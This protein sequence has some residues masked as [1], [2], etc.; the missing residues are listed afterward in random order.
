MKILSIIGARPQFI[1]CAPL[2]G[3]LRKEHQEVL[4]HTGQHYDPEMSDRFFSDL[5][6]PLPDHNL[7]IG[8]GKHGEQT[9]KMLAGIEEVILQEEPDLVLVYGDTNSTLAGG[10]AASKLNIPLAHVESGLRS[11]DRTMPEE[12]NRV[13]T[14]H[15]SN[16]LLCPTDT[17]V[18]NLKKEGLTENVYNVTDVMTDAVLQN[19]DIA[20]SSCDI[21]EKLVLEPKDYMLL[22]MHRPA[23]TDDPE[24]LTAI[25]D[26]LCSIGEKIVFPVHPRTE[27]YL[28]LYGL[29]DRLSKAITVIPPAGY[30]DMLNLISN[31]KKMITDSGGIQ[32]EAYILNVP[33]VTLREN[34]EWIE[35]IEEGWNVLVGSDPKKIRNALIDFNPAGSKKDVF[36]K[37]DA[38]GKIC[39]ILKRFE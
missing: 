24:K 22:T 18:R 3:A 9:G 26:T 15:I 32:K 34:T 21:L 13:V 39:E 10:L 8:S 28:R 30:L 25:V 23:N 4:V 5:K 36:G 19:R 33:C 31:A 2:S 12:I 27:K 7:E 1:K 17:A 6:I 11:F 16:I 14:D 38:S 37:G 20:K 29:M 35:T